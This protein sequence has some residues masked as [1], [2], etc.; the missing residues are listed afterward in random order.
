MNI[1]SDITKAI[2][3]TPLVEL[4]RLFPSGVRVLAKVESFNPGGSV[5][6]RVAL[7]IIEAAEASGKLPAGGTIVEATS[8]NTGVGLAMVGAARGYQVVI[9]MPASMSRERRLLMQAYGAQVVLT[10]PQGGMAA[11]VEAAERIVSQRPGAILASQFDNPA[12]PSTHYQRTGEEIWRDTDGQVAAVVAGVGT[13]GT[14]SGVGRALRECGS[15]ALLVAVEP[16][17]S[18]LITTGQA[19]PH[20]IQGI[21]A[22]FIPANYDPQVVDEVL[23]V[24]TDE[25][26]SYARQVAAQEG[27][28]VGISAGAALAGAAR[29]S[30]RPELAGKDVVVVLPDTG[31]R[32]LST[33][34][35]TELDDADDKG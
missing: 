9:T 34:L 16:A 6:D 11:A 31:E 18:A 24:S 32:Y 19:G 20:G 25:A 15:E 8:G 1:L 22:N 3:Q 28:L 33:A 29:L 30:Q 21:G 23:T 17:E 4:S 12:N 14:I 7:A 13:G 26:M 35:W 27:I 2:G 10:D 5:K